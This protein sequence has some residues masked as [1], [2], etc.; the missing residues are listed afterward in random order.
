MQAPAL[1]PDSQGVKDFRRNASPDVLSIL[2]LASQRLDDGVDG[3]GS[4]WQFVHMLFSN[5]LS[6]KSRSHIIKE[7]A[8]AVCT[9]MDGDKFV[10]ACFAGV[11]PA[12]KAQK[13]ASPCGMRLAYLRNQ[14]SALAQ[15]EDA[16]AKRQ[17]LRWALLFLSLENALAQPE[18]AEAKR[19]RLKLIMGVGHFSSSPSKMCKVATS[20]ATA[21]FA[22]GSGTGFTRHAPNPKQA[23]EAVVLHAATRPLGCLSPLTAAEGG[24]IPPLFLARVVTRFPD[25]VPDDLAR[26]VL[27]QSPSFRS[28]TS[29]LLIESSATQLEHGSTHG[30]N[31]VVCGWWDFSMNERKLA[32]GLQTLEVKMSFVSKADDG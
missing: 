7:Q 27:L 32:D 16:E 9:V 30:I 22:S 12:T 4:S 8:F 2:A 5:L 13:E 14:L 21:A 18:D 23:V 15:P 3:N 20:L 25:R 31:Q 6:E 29:L 24:A 10:L 28:L 1:N 19:Q 17:R 26:K 11:A